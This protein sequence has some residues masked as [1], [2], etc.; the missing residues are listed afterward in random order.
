MPFRVKVS[1]GRIIAV[2]VCKPGVG[3]HI[4]LK[5]PAGPMDRETRQEVTDAATR[6][7]HDARL[8]SVTAMETLY[9][10]ERA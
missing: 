8:A 7:Y 5:E 9:I 3:C 1:D 2:G 6:L 4:S 10:V